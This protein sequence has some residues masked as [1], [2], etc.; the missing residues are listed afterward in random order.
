MVG[1]RRHPLKVYMVIWCGKRRNLAQ[2]LFGRT[3]LLDIFGGSNVDF[4]RNSPLKHQATRQRGPWPYF[5]YSSRSLSLR[6]CAGATRQS[7][8]G[9]TRRFG[10][11]RLGTVHWSRTCLRC[12]NTCWKLVDG[13]IG[14]LSL[15]RVALRGWQGQPHVNERGAK[16]MTS[17]GKLG[18]TCY[19]TLGTALTAHAQTNDTTKVVSTEPADATS[20]AAIDGNEVA[21]EADSKPATATEREYSTFRFNS[22][23]GSTGTLHLLSADSGAPGTFRLS[24]LTSYYAGDGFLCP[25]RSQCYAPPAGVTA[26]QDTAKR[27][28]SALPLT[29]TPTSFLE[30][31]PR[32]TFRLQ[33]W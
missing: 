20:G 14:A 17:L 26:G 23:I 12:T 11:F 16:Q 15:P 19:F 30:A 13:F 3:A 24:Y 4:R 25:S 6:T 2:L 22:A 10:N 9:E 28:S 7:H 8:P 33:C 27:S 31:S 21:K 29:I 5:R 18:V 1:R 32:V